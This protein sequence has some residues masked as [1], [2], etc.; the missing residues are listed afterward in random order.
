MA[1]DNIQSKAGWTELHR[2]FIGLEEPSFSLD[3]L[4]SALRSSTFEVNA[5]DVFNKPALFY[6]LRAYPQAVD[7][8]LIVGA[9]PKLVPAC[10]VEAIHNGAA[11]A[12]GPLIRAG[13][14]VNERSK[15]GSH[16]LHILAMGMTPNCYEVALELVRHGGQAL[17]WDAQN[18]S[19]HTAFD[20]AQFRWRNDP[21]NSDLKKIFE[22]IQTRKLQVSGDTGDGTS[23]TSSDHPLIVSG[24]LGNTDSISAA[25]SG[26]ASINA[27]DNEGR[28]LLHLVAMGQ[29]TNGYQVAL[30]IVRCGGYAVDWDALTPEGYTALTLAQE[31]LSRTPDRH[32]LEE[33][34]YI[35]G[36]LS[37]RRLPPG[38]CYVYP[39]MDLN[40]YE[41]TENTETLRMPGGL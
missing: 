27:R 32:P 30:E 16:P 40:Y 38:E 34:A 14:D 22:L 1:W 39:C 33:T 18:D 3:E 37:A 26:G 7:T 24:L 29:A 9:D 6:A 2:L 35:V 31:R 20:F 25:V 5:L 28:T 10:I 4:A 19:G 15:G 41:Y 11:T 13:I 21:L 8:L 17:D 36:L 23:S 12:I